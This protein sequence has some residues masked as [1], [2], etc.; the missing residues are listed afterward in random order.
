MA[1][2]S[3]RT[4]ISGALG[5]LPND[6]EGAASGTV[7][8]IPEVDPAT[9]VRSLIPL[10]IRAV[11]AVDPSM[12]DFMGYVTRG[13]SIEACSAMDEL[14]LNP[15][16]PITIR[17]PAPGDRVGEWLHAGLSHPIQIIGSADVYDDILSVHP[18]EIF[19]IGF[20]II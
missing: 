6:W 19:T 5:I 12:L 13:W 10:G 11:D 9:G 15:V 14:E 20:E 18:D 17:P 7:C 4:R 16:A 2:N 8:L 3:D 1:E